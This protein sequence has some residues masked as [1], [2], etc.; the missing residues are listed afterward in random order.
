MSEIVLTNLSK[1]FGDVRAVD[2]L[3]LVIPSGSFFTLLGPSGCGKTTTLRMI[4]GLTKPTS[5]R[6]TIGDRTVF[7][8]KTWSI[9]PPGKREL[10][11]V[12]QSYALWPHMT[13]YDNI[14]FPL[15]IKK[16][17]EVEIKKRIDG[18]TEQVQIRGLENRYPSELSGG[19]QQRVAV[20]RELVTG[21]D[22]LLMD[23]P[24]GNLDARLRLEMRTE[25]KRL[26]Q[27]TGQTII[28]VT[29]DQLEAMTMSTHVAIMKDGILQQLSSADDVYSKPNNTFVAG[30]IGDLPINLLDMEIKG[31]YLE[32]CNTGVHL[33]IPEVYKN[34]KGKVTLGVRPE[35]V[36][37]IDEQRSTSVKA[38]VDTVL[39]AG[40]E[41]LLQVRLKDQFLNIVSPRGVKAQPGDETYIDIDMEEINLFDQD[42][43]ANLRVS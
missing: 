24:L 42:T 11:M 33:P 15:Q 1:H 5:G 18:V 13:V 25:L 35:S 16:M 9:I 19:Q 7:D 12:F 23:E 2:E 27:D 29:H 4:A 28:Y 8:S 39:P 17:S 20:A 36:K 32:C 40:S 22:V 41:V 43:G 3:D 30:F 6:I 21:V 14:A 31:E 38:I 10:G 34:A 37:I 26:H